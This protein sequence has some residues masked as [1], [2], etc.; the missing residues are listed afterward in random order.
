MS[1]IQV[2][3]RKIF[4]DPVYGFVTIPGD[5]V[6]DIIEHP[7]FQRL[8]RIKQ[9][10]LA[11]LVYPGALHTRF[12]HSLGAM[13]LM[14]KALTELKL[15]GHAITQE[16]QIASEAAMLLH[17]VGHGPYS[18]ALEHSIVNHVGHEKLSIWFMQLLN[19]EFGGRL[20]MAL[21]IFE[22]RYKKHF[23]HKLITS[24]F[25]MDRLDY[26]KRDS[27]FTGVSEGTINYERLLNM[28]QIAG[29]EP[30][31]EY[32]GIY[33]VEKFITARRIMYW[34]VYLHKTVLVAEYMAIHLLKRAKWLAMNGNTLKAATPAL[35]FFLE[36]NIREKHFLEDSHVLE[37]FALL[38]DYDIYTSLK[39]W[40]HHP[41]KI[42]SHL[43]RALVNR[44][45]FRIEMQNEPF[46]QDRIDAIREATKK[47]YH[48][49]EDETDYFVFFEKTANYTYHPG[50]DNINILF[51]DGTVKDIT[52]VSDQL[53]INLLSNPTTKY[54]LCYPKD[55]TLFE[56]N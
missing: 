42:L 16:E 56:T 43:S 21:E 39:L 28:L 7:V 44:R 27:F 2:N 13:H 14:T 12:H 18:H 45:L 15:K 54:F 23:L 49:I 24:Q 25:D 41:D 5:R 53:N 1:K 47:K 10:G 8:R 46:A 4:N 38:D 36:N 34:Q 40:M 48:L 37:A 22:D 33:S 52:E 51:K 17:D 30:V 20:Q 26:L 6:F 9:L 11:H 19:K 55:V 35:Q 3:K 29:D 50:T 31:I 32:K